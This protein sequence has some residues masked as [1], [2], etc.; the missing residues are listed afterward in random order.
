[1]TST[2]SPRYKWIALSNTT[3][4]MLMATIN[5]SIILISLPA[6]FKGIG[7]NP[8]SPDNTS[9]LL[10]LMMG[11]Q[12]VTAVGVVSLGRLGD[13]LG[14]VRIYNLGFAVFAV[15][16]IALALVPFT[17][18]AGAIWL[19]V[20][21]M[22]QGLGGAMLFANSSAIITDAFPPNRRGFATGIN[23][24]AAIAGSFLGLIIGGLLAVVDWRAIFWVSVPFSV[25]G[26]VW[27]F[28]S[29]R[30]FKSAGQVVIDWWGNTT[31]A[32]G[33]TALL[34][35][36]IYGIQPYGS[37]SMGWGSPWVL[38]AIIGGLI[39][40]FIFVLIELKARAPMVDLALFRIRAFWTGSFANFMSST[41]RGGLQFMLIIWLQGI[42]LPLHGFSFESTP[43]WSAIYLLPLTV[44]F[45]IAGPVAG[46]LSDRI[47]ARMLGTVGMGIY[48]ASFIALIFLP[49]DFNY[50]TF[51]ALIF[52]NGLGTGMFTAPNQTA[53]MNSVPPNRR[54]ASAGIQG[55]LSN[56]G[57]V[58]SMGLFFSLMIIGLAN[59][60]PANITS[61]LTSN[62]VSPVEAAK[63]AALPPAAILFSTFLGYNPMGMLLVSPTASHLT[64]GQ[65]TV[66]TSNEFFPKMVSS[67]FASGLTLVFGIAAI[68][69]IAGGILSALRGKMVHHITDLAPAEHPR[70]HLHDLSTTSAGIPG[71]IAIEDN[72]R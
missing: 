10:W 13:I 21:R 44:A 68:M 5:S 12:L 51:C 22:V 34:V 52:L 48:A 26:S 23:Q 63:I 7:V 2:P 60:L 49:V 8:L 57:M 46:Y 72:R 41:A 6:I 39:L 55:L 29:L 14:R 62:G 47:G 36:I 25:A 19:I 65:W 53:V 38:T 37:S 61:A 69:A 43:F 27:A 35:G 17:H 18:T 28:V 3:L 59:H 1:M 71:E 16:S 50:I 42:W 4:G 54:G 70:D 11:Y 67:S 40:L 9:L 31:F 58:L 20:W 30:N 66:L 45:L 32:V 15:S 56:S 24:I 64:P 33:L